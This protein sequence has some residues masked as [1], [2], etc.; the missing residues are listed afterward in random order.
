MNTKAKFKQMCS[1]Y[2]IE[3]NDDYDWII[4][5][6]GKCLG[7]ADVDIFKIK[8]KTNLLIDNYDDLIIPWMEN[9]EVG[10]LLSSNIKT[11]LDGLIIKPN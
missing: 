8:E 1:K 11:F 4:S 5:T 10:Q 9:L 6:L 3:F 2:F 7:I